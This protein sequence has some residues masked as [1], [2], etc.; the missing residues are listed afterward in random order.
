MS[1][2]RQKQALAHRPPKPV[3]SARK[4]AKCNLPT[5]P[6]TAHEQASNQLKKELQQAQKELHASQAELARTGNAPM[7]LALLREDTAL[8][9]A[10]GLSPLPTDNTQALVQTVAVLAQRDNLER[11][12]STLKERCETDRRPASASESALLG[13]ALAWHNHN[14]R[15]RPYLLIEAAPGMAYD[16][17][18][19]VRSCHTHTGETVAAQHLPG[20]ADGSGTLLCKA[21]VGTR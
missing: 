1:L 16:Y 11:L 20:I 9:Q 4:P 7:E 13:A 5:A 8:A 6:Q 15:T 19:H 2:P 17:E 10:L 12:W 21:L 14:W 3:P 18:R